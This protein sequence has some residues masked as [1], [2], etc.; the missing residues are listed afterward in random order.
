MTGTSKM[1]AE[2]ID[3]GVGIS[4]SPNQSYENGL[5]QAS[6]EKTVDISCVIPTY[7]A[8]ACLSPLVTR[9]EA[10]LSTIT[11]S[12]EILF[13]E[14]HSRDDSWSKLESLVTEHKKLR[15]LRLS[16]NFGQHAAITAGLSNCRGRFAVVMDCD[17]QDPPEDIYRLWQKANEGF[18]I[19]LAR[20][21][22]K[23]HSFWRVVLSNLYFKLLAFFSISS[24]SGNFGTF[25]IISRKVIDAYVDLK[26]TNRH[27][28][29]ILQ[30]LGFEKAYIDYQHGD[31]YE[32]KS[33]YSLKMLMSHA[34][35]GVFFQTTM[36]LQLI[37]SLGLIISTIGMLAAVI[38][39]WN[40]F[41]HSALPG[42]TSVTVL[43][44]VIGGVNL[45]SVGTVGLYVGQIFDQ[46]KFRPLFIIDKEI[47]QDHADLS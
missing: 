35:Q 37:V 26:D 13:V 18:E 42:W 23:K 4:A 3:F 10:A 8:S 40:Y 20:R 39:V 45:I 14:D 22:E 36:L 30:W 41:V 9:L 25:S 43:I 19:V 34:L 2:L 6:A 31:R 5:D 15:A 24:V 29:M 16:R 28:L 38:A 7:N 12:Y 17:L 11:D 47:G 21:I 44:L 1:H 46:V 33:S 27:Y 32:G